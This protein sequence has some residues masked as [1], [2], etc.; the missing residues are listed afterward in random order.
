MYVCVFSIPLMCLVF[1]NSGF[2]PPGVNVQPCG[3]CW[4]DDPFSG[5]QHPLQDFVV[6]ST[7][8]SVLGGDLPWEDAV[9]GD[10]LKGQLFSWKFKKIVDMRCLSHLPYSPCTVVW[11]DQDETLQIY[12]VLWYPMLLILSI[13]VPLIVTAVYVRLCPHNQSSLVLLTFRN[14]LLAW[15]QQDNFS[16]FPPCHSWWP[17]HR[18]MFK[19]HNG[20]Q[21]NV[22]I[23]SIL[24][25]PKHRAQV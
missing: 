13:R 6:L 2:W 16:T 21:S 25:V 1:K 7:L 4:P 11:R 9:C 20:L 24:E 18:V 10:S 5:P 3:Q 8:A 19:L 17:G 12:C 22:G 15:Y 23:E 14:R